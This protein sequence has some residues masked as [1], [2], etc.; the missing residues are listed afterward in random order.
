MVTSTGAAAHSRGAGEGSRVGGAAGARRSGTDEAEL[1]SADVDDLTDDELSDERLAAAADAIVGFRHSDRWIFGTMLFSATLSLIAAFVLSYD[2]V[3]LAANPTA[4]LSC[5]INSVI[6]CGTVA[7][8][9]QA[10]L[11]GFPN[12]F[13]GMVTEPVVITIAVAALS[14]VRFPRWFMFTA[15]VVYAFGLAFALWLFSQS[16]WVIG[17]LCPWCML[18]TVSTSLVFLT[19]LHYNIRENNLYLPPAAQRRVRS[20]VRED[21]DLYAGIAFVVLLATLVLVQHGTVLFS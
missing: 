13:L 21:Y 18:I 20:W 10:S 11:F 8:S 3:E 9:W 19:L 12:A 5:D 1:L 15:Q 16:M 4:V 14:G 17:A 2:A 6:S 7:L